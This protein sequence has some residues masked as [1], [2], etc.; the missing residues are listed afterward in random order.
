MKARI[1]AFTGSSET[2]AAI[3]VLSRSSKSGAAD[4]RNHDT[5]IILKEAKQ[6]VQFAEEEINFDA[7]MEPL[8]SAIE[9]GIIEKIVTAISDAKQI[10]AEK[11]EQEGYQEFCQY[12]L[13]KQGLL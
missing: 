11:L 5:E 4:R 13:K 12:L 1:P 3:I 7:E 9:S 6:I 2:A 8:N 10:A